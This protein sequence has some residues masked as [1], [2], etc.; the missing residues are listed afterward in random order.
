[1]KIL[2]YKLLD[3]KEDTTLIEICLPIGANIIGK[4]NKF[5]CGLCIYFVEQDDAL[6]NTFDNIK[7]LVAKTGQDFNELIQS[8]FSSISYFD[9][10]NIG[11]EDEPIV[12]HLLMIQ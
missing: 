5:K 2:K 3:I 6:E 9:T 4:I 7:I 1:M 12:R 8:S 10:I 11:T